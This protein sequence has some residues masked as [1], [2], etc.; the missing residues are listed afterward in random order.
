MNKPTL[1]RRIYPYLPPIL[2][3]RDKDLEDEEFWLDQGYSRAS[4]T[5]F[6]AIGVKEAQV[7]QTNKG[8]DEA[9]GMNYIM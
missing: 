9:N 8:E 5:P 4:I 7:D 6:R 1:I 2:E 3:L